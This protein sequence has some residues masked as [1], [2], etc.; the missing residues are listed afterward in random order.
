M[1]YRYKFMNE[2]IAE[3]NPSDEVMCRWLLTRHVFTNAS[4][5]RE[6]ASLHLPDVYDEDRIL[7]L[8]AIEKSG[9]K[10]VLIEN[11]ERCPRCL[12]NHPVL[13]ALALSSPD[14]IWTHFVSCPITQEPFFITLGGEW[15]GYPGLPPRGLLAFIKRDPIH[16]IFVADAVSKLTDAVLLNREATAQ[17]LHKSWFSPLAWVT[18]A[19]EA[20]KLFSKPFTSQTP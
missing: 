2:I 11:T 3:H 1:S 9:K 15:Q 4:S 17:E 14:G 7:A 8:I 19:E 12:G 10:G 16:L 18:A 6:S 20:A 13:A 5:A